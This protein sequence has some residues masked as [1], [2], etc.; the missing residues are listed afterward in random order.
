MRSTLCLVAGV[1]LL[2]VPL[3]GQNVNTMHPE[4]IHAQKPVSAEDIRERVSDLQF[5]KD[6]KEL[7]DLCASVPADLDGLQQGLLPKKTIEK[8]R[9]MEKL[10]KRVRE[11]LTRIS[12]P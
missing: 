1:F 6:T 10:S 4:E 8:L 3:G 5:Q 11:Q 2:G 12:A 7:A 9:R